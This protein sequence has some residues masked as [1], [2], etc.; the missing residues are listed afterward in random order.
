MV[1]EWFHIHHQVTDDG[2]AVDRL[3][4]NI[5]AGILYERFTCQAVVAIDPHRI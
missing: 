5:G 4:L 2:Q 3:Y 1:K